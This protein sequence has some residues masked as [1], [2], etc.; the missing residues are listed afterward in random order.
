MKK[1]KKRIFKYLQ[2]VIA[3]VAVRLGFYPYNPIQDNK[4]KLLARAF[5]NLKM[6][7]FYPKTILD[8]GANHGTWTRD[9]LKIFPDSSYILVEPQS[10]LESSIEDLKRTAKIK[11]F[12]IGVG[13]KNGTFE[14]SINE[15]DDSSSFRPVE[16]NIDG[17]KFVKKIKVPM[18]TIDSFLQENNLP[19]PELIKIDA[20]GLDLEVLK[21]A[22]SIFEKT[23]CILIEASIHQ[24]AFPNSFLKVINFMEDRGYEVFDI[25]DLNRP[26]P[27]GLLWLVEVLF[28]KKNSKFVH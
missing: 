12:P 16:L 13:S 9:S 23:E 7:G 6:N 14:F 19:I 5:S 1:I 22:N 15:S 27:N 28:V 8:I 11:F 25:T 26:F 10:H 4:S 21:G 2:K 17:Y 3:P 20:E 24:R 18:R